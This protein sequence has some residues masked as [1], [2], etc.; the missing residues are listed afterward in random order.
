MIQDGQVRRLQKLLSREMSWGVAA[1]KSG[2][3]EKRARSVEVHSTRFLPPAPEPQSPSPPPAPLEPG[4][5]TE[6]S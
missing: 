6:V 1:V 4:P 2:I 5:G 3:R